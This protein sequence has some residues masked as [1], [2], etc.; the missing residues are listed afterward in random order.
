MNRL[1][2]I[3]SKIESAQRAWHPVKSETLIEEALAAVRELKA[4]KPVGFF[5][6][7][8]AVWHQYDEDHPAYTP[9]YRLD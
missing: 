9:L 5:K 6:E 4:L 8:G 1:D 3:I 2:L 7:K